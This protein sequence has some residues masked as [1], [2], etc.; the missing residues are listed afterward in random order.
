M[1]LELG[2]FL[3]ARRFGDQKQKQKSRVVLDTE[4]YRYQQYISD[5]AGQDIKAHGGDLQRA[6]NSVRDW[7]ASRRGVSAPPGLTA[8]FNRF[9]RFQADLPTLCHETD[10]EEADR[11]NC[12]KNCTSA[13]FSGDFYIGN[14]APRISRDRS[15]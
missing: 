5:I 7:L 2:M 13:S 11:V 1:P 3:G 12:A 8:I 6:I 15:V 9:N 4:P 10:R 14:M